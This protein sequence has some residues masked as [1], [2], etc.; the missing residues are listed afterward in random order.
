MLHHPPQFDWLELVT[1]SRPVTYDA[2]AL[3]V[4]GDDTEERSAYIVLSGS[5]RLSLPWYS[6][7]ACCFPPAARHPPISLTLS[8]PRHFKRFASP[9]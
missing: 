5:V 7:A 3:I 8:L 2:D 9:E 4:T 6:A 1:I